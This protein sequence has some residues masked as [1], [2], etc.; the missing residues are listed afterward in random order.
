MRNLNMTRPRAKYSKYMILF[1]LGLSLPFLGA[2]YPILAEISAPLKASALINAQGEYSSFIAKGDIRRFAGETLTYD[3]DFLFFEKAATAKVRF[4]N[5]KG[6]ILRRCLPKP[7]GWWAFSPTTGSTITSPHSI[8]SIRAD[9][10]KP[11]NLKEM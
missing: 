11:E 5:T 3:I 1:A 2:F 7:R 4:T 10:S 6:N 9:E 8:S